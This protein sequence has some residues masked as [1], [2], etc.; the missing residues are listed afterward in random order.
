MHAMLSRQLRRALQAAS[1]EDADSLLHEVFALATG[2]GLNARQA[3]AL[4]GLREVL[5]RVEESYRQFDRAQELRLRSLT[6]SSSELME[7]NRR[8]REETEQQRALIDAMRITANHLLS[9]AGRAPIPVN[10]MSAP[11]VAQLMEQLIAE[12]EAA[13]ARVT[14]SESRFRGLTSLS[15]DWY[16]EQ[17]AQQRFTQMSQG[18]T[19]VT[20]LK[21][22]AFIG[23]TGEEAFAGEPAQP[24]W[25]TQ[26]RLLQILRE[27]QPFREVEL[28]FTPADG[29]PVFITLSGEPCTGADGKF[30]GYRGVARNITAQK[31]AENRLQEVLHLMETLLDVTPTPITIKDAG[32]RFV[33]VNA[34]FLRMFGMT[35][36]DWI[37]KTARELRG[38]VAARG[39]A[40]EQDLLAHPR[41]IRYDQQRTLADGRVASYIVTKAPMLGADGSVSR[42]ISTYTDITELKLV[43]EQLTEQLA[44][45]D[46]LIESMPMP[47]SIKDREH[48]FVRLNAAYEREFDVRRDEALG[49]TVLNALNAS[50]LGG[51]EV[52]VEMLSHPSV[53]SY[54][55]SRLRKD[56]SESYFVITK[57]PRLDASGAVTGFITTHADVTDLKQIEQ[58]LD[59]QLRFTN[60]I[61]ETSPEPMMVKNRSRE[62]TYVNT[63]YEK[64]FEVERKDIIAL[65]MRPLSI[66]ATQD[67]QRIELA[68][69]ANPGTRQFE[70]TLPTQSGRD[71]YCIVTKS[72]FLD[73][74]GG[75]GG[76]ITTYS[77][78]SG[79]KAAEQAKAEQ[80]RL[81]T[82]F[83]DASPTP[84]V[85]KD[86]NLILTRCNT[87]YEQLFGV[88]REDILH[89]P[90]SGHRTQF[91]EEVN[92]I[93]RRLLEEPGTHRVERTLHVSGKPDIFCVI[94]KSTYF[95]GSGEVEGV[96]TTFTDIS[97]LK[98]TE[99]SLREAKLAA[100]QAMRTRSQFLANMSHEIRTP[101]NGVLGMA[102]VLAGT[103]L[104]AEQREYLDI[105][106]NSGES[107]LKIVNDILDFSKIEAGKV[108]L[109]WIAFDLHSR[110][111]SLM[112]LFSASAREKNLTLETYYAEDVP[113]L[114]SGDPVRI[115]QV[116]SNLIGNAIKFTD[117]GTIAVHV[118]VYARAGDDLMLRFDVRDTGIGISPE[119]VERIFD[120]FSQEDAS[121]TR[122][123]GGTGLGLTISRQLV[124][125]MGGELSVVTT[126]GQGSVFSFTVKVQHGSGGAEAPSALSAKS[127]VTVQGEFAAL[128]VLLAEDNT[129]NQIVA[130][131]ILKKLGCAVTIAK[132]GQAAVDAARARHYD[133]IL[134][135]CHMPGVDGFAATAAIRELEK[136]GQPRHIIIAQ[137][138]NAM[139][140]DRE[141]CLAAGMDD[142]LAKPLSS[143][144]L[145]QTLRRWAPP[146][147]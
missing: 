141:T 18:I 88:R 51:R 95:N 98:K 62:I 145:A 73:R 15:S 45:T 143:N 66:A 84:T 77:D 69:L 14:E 55:R 44:L 114:V 116:L 94:E 20:G 68:L 2:N 61:L 79:L 85:I 35:R 92:V 1:P 57:A 125:L 86:K 19:A 108:E 137:T 63:A 60:V 47:V 72:T 140:G 16:W 59:E 74:E 75:V 102:D 13:H 96:I 82:T 123:F 43:Q 53:R 120:P 115:S 26:Q 81:T 23:Q 46:A 27:R 34:A 99:E 109:E 32:L 91:A 142:Y 139:E 31:R 113:A 138:A 146:S 93:E 130:N 135:D 8:L 124:G 90:M 110:V 127:A 80:L 107:L 105:I 40:E 128:H 70:Y 29:E 38:D 11:H 42:V 50:A 122:R 100:E 65:K 106:R 132:D 101:M 89:Q 133:A 36:E 54:T 6:I 104:A 48:R 119:A 118:G 126:Q 67:I 131:A 129:I 71:V 52:E 39:E 134:M 41:V 22:E 111:A 56:G 112:Q 10:E 136:Q 3:Q 37:G 58:R 21:P 28:C 9:A 83:L 64:L 4:N 103:P 7:A 49:H 117:A 25:N 76:I 97:E 78:V 5:A 121:T 147:A 144:A 30:S 33:R 24:S 17:D 12:S 87:A